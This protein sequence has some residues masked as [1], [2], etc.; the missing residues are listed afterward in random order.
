LH[1][2]DPDPTLIDLGVLHELA[3]A[4]APADLNA[5]V[6]EYSVHARIEFEQMLRFSHAGQTQAVKS[7]AHRLAG[8]SLNLGLSKIAQEFRA[9]ENSAARPIGHHGRLDLMLQQSL[10]WLKH[11]VAE[12]Q[13]DL[14]G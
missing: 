12:A 5:I 13:R 10:H 2:P 7:L 9:I 1:N 8:T 6:S 14:A 4:L 3:S 11:Y